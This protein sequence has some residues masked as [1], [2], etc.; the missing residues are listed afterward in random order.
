MKNIAELTKDLTKLYA[1]LRS[2]K[3]EVKVASEMN[4]TAGKLIS[5]QKVQLDYAELRKESPD[6]DFLNV[7]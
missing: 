2:G 3:I 4:N 1:D 5:A 6:I 7:K